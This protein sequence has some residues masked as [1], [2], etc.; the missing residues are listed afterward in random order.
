MEEGEW[1]IGSWRMEN[2]RM[3]DWLMERRLL[4]DPIFH[5]P[6]SIFHFPFF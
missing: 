4:L 6:F 1:K 5:H 3:K 2:R